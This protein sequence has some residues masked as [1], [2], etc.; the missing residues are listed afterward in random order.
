MPLPIN[1]GESSKSYYMKKI[2]VPIDFSKNSENALEVAAMLAKKHNATLFP[3]HMLDIQEASLNESISYKHEK[4]AFYLKLAEK[5]FKAF[6]KKDF[7]VDLEVMPL[8]KH[9]KIFSEIDDIAKE[10]S[11]DLIV[12]GSHGASGLKEFFVGSNT[13]KVVRY[14]SIPVLVVKNKLL[15]VDFSDIVLATDLSQAGVPAFK[16]VLKTLEVFKA[17]KHIIYVN[18]PNEKF[19][20]TTEMEQM[21]YNFFMEVEGNADRML[22]MNF[23]CDRSIEEGILNFSNAIGADLIS[24]ITHGRRG[25]SHIFSGSI[26]EDITNHAALP[27]MTFKMD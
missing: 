14:A 6:L 15:N 26:A 9:F 7:L 8:I 5:N 25:L 18:L 21:A 27:I 3:L 24:V 23:I 2:I 4:T 20:S 13:E 17:R 12:M 22:S 16:N 1:F 11:A 10:I 19:K